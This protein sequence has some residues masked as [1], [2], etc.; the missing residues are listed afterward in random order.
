[1]SGTSDTHRGALAAE[2][3]AALTSAKSRIGAMRAVVGFDVM[4]DSIIRVVDRKDS[5]SFTP[6]RKIDQLAERVAKA[7]GRSINIEFRVEQEKLGGNGALMGEGLARAGARVSFIGSIGGGGSG[8]VHPVFADFAARCEKVYPTGGPGLTD[9]LEFDDGKVL[10]G[11][12]A[13]LEHITWANVVRAVGG[14]DALRSMI[15]GAGCF[16]PVSWTQVPRMDEIWDGV[17]EHVLPK[18]EA[19]R[20]PAIFID[21]AD[22]KKRTKEALVGALGRLRKL[23]ELAPVTLGLNL[24]ESQQIAAALGKKEP[25]T[26]DEGAPMIRE[27]LGLS[28]VVTHG[29]RAGAAASKEGEVASF[30]GPYTKT[31]KI[32][33]G[34]GDHFNAGFALASGLG[35]PA[36][37]RLAV[38]SALSGWYVRKGLG[39]TLDELIGFLKA[40]PEGEK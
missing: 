1:M 40:L 26:L 37:Q 16:V 13:A 34:A 31:P 28:C 23:N 15:D 9:A 32:S 36:G 5:A 3:A 12:T 21:L 22:P 27:A 20:R 11:K 18:I 29:H 2:A 33:T 7:A 38:A 19:S 24:S 30:E 6:M 17:I 14:V 25:Q 10:L 35:L 8:G 39:P 4:I